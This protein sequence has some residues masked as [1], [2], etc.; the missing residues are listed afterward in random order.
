[1]LSLSKYGW[2]NC[3]IPTLLSS[4][5]L[6]TLPTWR[7]LKILRAP[8]NRRYEPFQYFRNEA[9]CFFYPII[10]VGDLLDE[11][12]YGRIYKAYR[13][14]YDIQTGSSQ[15]TITIVSKQTPVEISSEERKMSEEDQEI[16]YAEEIQALIFEAALHILAYTALK[17]AGYPTV[18]P[19]LFDVVAIPRDTNIYPDELN[20]SGIS[21]VW[22]QME[23]IRGENLHTFFKSHVQPT[24]TPE[25]NDRIIVDILIQLCVYMDV[26]QTS[27][28]FNHR[29][30]KL[31]NILRRRSPPGWSKTITHA[32]LQRPWICENDLAIIDFGFSCV[33]CEDSFQSLIQAGSWFRQDHDCLKGGR[34]MALFIYCM[35]CCYPLRS[36]ISKGLWD[37]LEG[38]MVAEW[39]G[40][41]IRLLDVG[42]DSKGN[43]HHVPST[44]L[45]FDE[46]IYRFLRHTGIEVPGCEP[47]TLMKSLE[48]FSHGQG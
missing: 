38:A 26:L 31:N 23:Y 22:I 33:A 5:F 45:V 36:R 35:H 3:N 14:V 28:Y 24:I 19:E 40:E 43:P 15:P 48:A 46:G 27:L 21:A 17:E 9:G 44:R 25:T 34:D 18:V 8:D 42:V 6:L 30:L 32:A 39:E 12:S 29:D 11:G 4:R 10:E 20:A 1:M 16:C 47:R 41:R 37:L 2:D 7:D 13:S